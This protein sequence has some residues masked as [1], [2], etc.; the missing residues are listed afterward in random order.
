MI[1]NPEIYAEESDTNDASNPVEILADLA[2]DLIDEQETQ[3][4]AAEPSDLA[5]DIALK[6]IETLENENVKLR[7]NVEEIKEERRIYSSKIEKITDKWLRPVKPV[8]FIGFVFYLIVVWLPGVIE[9][10]WTH[11][12]TDPGAKMCVQIIGIATMMTIGLPKPALVDAFRSMLKTLADPKMTMEEKEQFLKDMIYQIL[13]VWAD[14]SSVV[15]IQ[16][17]EIDDNIKKID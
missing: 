4:V 11:P 3:E 1:G 16:K 17:K 8:V 7:E 13:N 14:L 15:Q 5:L 10:D 6:K 12:G 9:I 2:N